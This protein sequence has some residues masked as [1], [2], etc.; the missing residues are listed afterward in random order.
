LIKK[1]KQR[2]CSSTAYL[3]IFLPLA[4]A[5]YLSSED[6]IMLA[7][8]RY[9]YYNNGLYMAES[10][11]KPLKKALNYYNENDWDN[12]YSVLTNAI[13]IYPNGYYTLAMQQAANSI[14]KLI[15][16]ENFMYN[17]WIVKQGEHPTRESYR[18][19]NLLQHFNP[20]KY[21]LLYNEQTRIVTDALA[22]YDSLYCA[23]NNSKTEECKKL[24][25]KYGWCWFEPT[26]LEILKSATGEAFQDN[27]SSIFSGETIVAAKIRLS[28]VWGL[29]VKSTVKPEDNLTDK[30][31]QI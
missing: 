27:M 20:K 9:F 25:D 2:E 4:V 23:Y 17:T 7:K 15:E 31:I 24:V 16:Y 28:N 26:V 10:Q 1:L 6:A 30:R 22:H 13:E 19:A 8:G 11:I 14:Q 3:I 5:I 12:C 21:T 18:C 29:E